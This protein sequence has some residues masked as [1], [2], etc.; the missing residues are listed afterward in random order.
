M[1]GNI[2]G[3][4]GEKGPQGEPGPKGDTGGFNG[5]TIGVNNLIDLSKLVPRSTTATVDVD[6]E[7]GIINYQNH[8]NDLILTKH[9]N[10]G[11]YVYSVKNYTRNSGYGGMR[12]RVS[13]GQGDDIVNENYT[14]EPIKFS[15]KDSTP[16]PV[17]IRIYPTNAVVAS[18][19]IEKP[20]LVEGEYPALWSYSEYDLK[21]LLGRYS[22]RQY[23]ESTIAG[24]ITSGTVSTPTV[25]RLSG[26]TG[27]TNIDYNNNVITLNEGFYQTNVTITFS[28]SVASHNA[29]VHIY[30]NGE[31]IYQYR[32]AD[33]ATKIAHFSHIVNASDNDELTIRIGSSN[34]SGET[35]GPSTWN[36][37]Q[38]YKL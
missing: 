9:L 33:Q 28:N 38:I 32:L 17:D 25:M 30:L 19:F 12:F 16:Q 7:N 29:T 11:D 36:K 8:N 5:E 1:L 35:L 23:Y 10:V 4:R 26:Q 20:V 34:A 27:S 2:K 6:L 15:I 14:G 3:P 22:L 13:N 24:S 21:Q 31:S 18:G 37:L